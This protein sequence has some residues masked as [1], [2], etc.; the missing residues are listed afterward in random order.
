VSFKSG[1][2][3]LPKLIAARGIIGGFTG[4]LHGGQQ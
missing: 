3:E 4:F 2:A 1:E